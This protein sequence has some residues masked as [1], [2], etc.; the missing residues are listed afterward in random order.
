MSNELT[1]KL[2]RDFHPMRF[3]RWAISDLNPWLQW[4]GPSAEIVRSQRRA[5]GPDQPFRQ[6]ET[7]VSELVSAALD[8]YRDIRDAT[9]EALFFQTY[10]SLFSLYLADKHEAEERRLAPPSDPRQMPSVREALASITVGGYAEAFTRA[11]YLLSRHGEPLPLT[12]LELKEDL[13]AEYRDLVPAIPRD[14]VR[15]I[16]GRQEI[17]CRYEPEHAIAS[18]PELL[19]DPVDRERFLTLL[20][21]IVTDP[22][23]QA[24]GL[25]EAQREMLA[26]IRGVFGKGA[27]APEHGLS[28]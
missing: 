19:L 5:S 25:T 7:M 12:R 15:R 1:A 26:R 11:G 23:F 2:G 27:N 3:Q 17:I 22:R 9:S 8:Y 10:G 4:L 28:E 21:R 24:V 16:R 14:A 6:V 20:D 13:L 18:L